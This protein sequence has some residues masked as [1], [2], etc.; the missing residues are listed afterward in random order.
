MSDIGLLIA[1]DFAPVGRV[2]KSIKDKNYGELFNEV[3]AVIKSADYAIVNLEAPIADS[4]ECRPIEKFGPNLKSSKNVAEALSAFGFKGATLANNHLRDY[5]DM[6]VSDTLFFLSRSGIDYFGAGLDIKEASE[7]KIIKVGGIN[8]AVINCCEHEFSIAG[9]ARPGA[10]PINPVRQ[11]YAIKHA[12][13]TADVVL[14]IVHGGIET[15]QLPTPRMQETYRFFIDAG[16]DA[17][18]NHHQHCYSGFEMYKGRPIFYGLGNFC[19]DWYG[20]IKSSWNEGFML[21]LNFSNSEFAS[22]EMLPYIQC[23]DHPGVRMMTKDEKEKFESTIT[24]L[25]EIIGEERKL[26]FTYSEF[27]KNN[28]IPYKRLLSPYT[29]KFATALYLRGWLPRLFSKKKMFSLLNKVEC[30]SHRERLIAFLNTN[31]ND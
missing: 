23:D 25:N 11:Y 17:V 26:Q 4:Q 2:S 9:K 5:G 19:F 22:F 28:T 13:E 1:G 30:E 12:R 10:N 29:S 7:T 31:I 15:Y 18:I 27:Q 3:A 21:K 14:V 6:G 20:K 24:N 16:A 8:L